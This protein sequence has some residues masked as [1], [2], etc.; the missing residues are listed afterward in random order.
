MKVYKGTIITCDQKDTVSQ[1]LVEENGKIVFTGNE[2]DEKYKKTDPID[3]GQKALI[4]CFTDSHLHFTSHAL[5]SSTLDVREA[6]DFDH[7]QQ[8]ISNYVRESAIKIVLGFGISAHSVREKRMITRKELDKIEK[9]RPVMLVKYD[10]HASVIN[11]AMLAILPKKFQQLRGFNADTGQL[12]QEAFFA[13]T[14]HISSKVSIVSLLKYMLAAVDEMASQGISLIHPVEG[15]GFPFD[16]DIDLVRFVSGG[17]ANPF[18]MR[19]FFQTMDVKKVL[20][21]KL[22]R[23][24]GCFATALDGCFGSVDAALLAPYQNDP[25]NKGILFYPDETMNDFVQ[26]AH[27]KGLQIQLHAI[28]D[29]AFEQAVNAF[30]LA[31]KNNPRKDHRHGIIHAS[32]I[33]Q[34]GL[35]TC[36]EHDIGVALQPALIHC[37]LEPLSYLQDIL[38]DRVQNMTPLRTL[39]DAGIH[40]SGGSDAP[41]TLPEPSYAI[42]AA[43]NHFNSSQSVSIMEALKMFTYETAWSSF[44]DKDRGTLEKGKRADMV[45]LDQNPLAM[46]KEDLYQLKV[47]KMLLEGRVYKE[48]QGLPSLLWNAVFNRR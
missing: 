19:L 20:K 48:G 8:I 5:F 4:P 3:L 47:E 27:D 22:P 7:L 18:A 13:A 34:K 39:L 38:G 9:K 33:T 25:G 17:L 11:S 41:V 46:N 28:G 44:D 15:V 1:Y 2:L 24:G 10:G 12:F 21:R 31:L 26:Q 45:V 6:K 16:L 32:L 43:C 35:E 37:N 36:A 14:D 30:K 42:Y 40:V 29:A 23:I